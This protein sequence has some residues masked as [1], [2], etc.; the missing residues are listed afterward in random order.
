MPS[1][2]K[3]LRD[4]TTVN[5]NVDG[6]GTPVD[7]LLRNTT[8]KTM[9]FHRMVVQCLDGANPSADNFGD[10]G[11]PLGNGIRILLLDDSDVIQQDITDGEPIKFNAQWAGLCFD[12]QLSGFGSGDDAINSRFTFANSGAP[13]M[14]PVGWAFAVR[15]QDDLQQITRLTFNCQ[16]QAAQFI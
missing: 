15:I 14:V 4:D 2:F 1:F 7:F 16:G 6:S 5:A 11:A 12:V 10:L 13:V 8:S 3:Y 9:E